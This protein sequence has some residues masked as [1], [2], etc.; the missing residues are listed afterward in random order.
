MSRKIISIALAAATVVAAASPSVALAQRYDGWDRSDDGYGRG[1]DDDRYAD[2]YHGEDRDRSYRHRD[3]R[4]RDD[5]DGRYYAER[6][7]YDRGDRDDDRRDDDRGYRE[8]SSSRCH[9]SGVGGA[10]FG[11]LAGALLGRGIASHHD[12]AMG[13]I[14]GGAGGAMAG[15]AIENSNNRC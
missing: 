2:R 12:N 14:I 13:T 3:W 10:L 11:G 9:S 8:R 5:E 1:Y 6:R 7:D 4:D 15:A